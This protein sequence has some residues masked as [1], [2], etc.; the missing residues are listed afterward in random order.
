MNRT[1]HP[2]F[3]PNGDNRKDTAVLLVGTAGEYGIDQRDIRM[4]RGGFRISQAVADALGLDTDEV[5][6]ETEEDV[7]TGQVPVPDSDAGPDYSEWEYPDLKA[8]VAKRGLDTEDKKSATLIAALLD[9]D[10]TASGNR[11]GENKE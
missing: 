2:Y 5:P 3:V 4:V 6:E 10:T 8:E 1:T 11:A 7:L 9:D